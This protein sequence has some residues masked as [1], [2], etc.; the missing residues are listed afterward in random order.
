MRKIIF[1]LI[2][3]FLLVYNVSSQPE[4][5]INNYSSDSL[6]SIKVKIYPISM[7]FNGEYEYNLRAKHP[8]NYGNFQYFYIAGVGSYI[9]DTPQ[10][11][12]IKYTEYIINRSGSLPRLIANHDNNSINAGCNFA[13]GF[14]KYLI[15]FWWANFN[16]PPNDYVTLEFDAGYRQPPILNADVNISYVDNNNDPRIE[17]AWGTDT[18]IRNTRDV[19]RK[20]ECWNQYGLGTRPKLNGNFRYGAGS[21]D[22][23]NNYSIIPQDPRRDCVPEV[24]PAFQ[25][26]QNHLF[27]F[28]Y[29]VN[30]INYYGAAD[31]G[32]LTLNLTVDKNITTP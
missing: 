16:E 25:F 3:A 11:H 5:F 24:Y 12:Q 10:V 21:Y 20:L 26:A 9:I 1:C 6:K 27:N 28:A 14:G 19:Q 15:Q 18:V 8:I 23:L 7:V 30:Y 13:F 22:C 29:I 17:F 32:K 2:C 31:I 4:V